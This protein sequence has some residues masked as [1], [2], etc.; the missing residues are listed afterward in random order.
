[1]LGGFEREHVGLLRSLIGKGKANEHTHYAYI[2]LRYNWIIL[3]CV[4]VQYSV[5]EHLTARFQCEDMGPRA[6]I[7]LS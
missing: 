5:G 6:H 7:L 1:M 4:S 2:L 3:I